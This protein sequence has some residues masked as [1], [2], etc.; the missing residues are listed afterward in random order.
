M[1]QRIIMAL[2]ALHSLVVAFAGNIVVGDLTMKPGET[3]ALEISLSGSVSNVYGIQFDIKLPKEFSFVKG[4]GDKVFEMAGNQA[5][6]ITCDNSELGEG[7]YRFLIY[8]TTLQ[9]L[10][11][12]SLISVNLI[13]N[14]TTTLGNYSVTI[15]NVAVS[16]S[17][18]HVT[19]EDGIAVSVKVTDFFTL[20]YQVDGEEYKSFEMEYGAIISPES[21]PTKEG[22]TFSGWNE[23]PETMPAQDVTIM[24]TFTAN[25]YKLTYFVDGKEYKTFEVEYGTSVNK[26]AF[27]EQEGYTFSGWSEIPETMPAHDVTVTGSFTVNTYTLTY[28]VDG[29]VYKTVD[30]AYGTAITPEDE[31]AKEGYTFS[32]WGDIATTMPANDVTVSGTF[33]VNTYT[34]TYQLDGEFY[35]SYDIDFGSAITPE[36]EPTKEGYSFSGWSEIPEVMPALDITVTGEFTINKYML[37]YI[38]DGEEYKSLELEYG[39]T[40]NSEAEPEKEG[41]TF[42]GWSEIPETMPAYDVIINGTFSVNTYTLTYIVDS[43]VYTTYVIDYGTAITPEED[44]TKEGHTFSGWSDIPKTMPAHDVNVTG[45]FTK[46]EY[47]LTYIVNGETYLTVSYDYGTAVIPE[48]EPTKEGYTFS[49]WSDIP[50]TMPANDITVTGTFTINSYKLTYVVDGEEYK[51]FEIE[52]GTSLNEEAEPEKEGHTFS[53]WSDIPETMPAN[54]V[55]IN[56]KFRI[57]TYKLT[58]VVDGQEYKSFEVEYGSSIDA[59]AEPTKEGH[60]FSGW[61]ELPET[62]PA[63]DLVATGSFTINKYVMTYTVDGEEYK[64]FEVEY[65][66][67]ITAEAI[68]EKEGYTFSGWSEI[69][70]TMP[71]NDVTVTG[72]FTVNT[73][74]LTYQVDGE[75]YKTCEVAYGTAITPEAEPEKEGY[76]FSGW[77]EMPETMPA[78]DVAVTG[79]FTINTYQVTYIIGG[80]V[81][82]TDSVQYG[83][84]IVVPDA[85]EREDYTFDGWADVPETMPAHDI[86]IY[87]SYTS[88]IVDVSINEKNVI[89]YDVKGRRI[90]KLQRG[91]NIIRTRD[92]RMRKVMVK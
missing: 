84:A 26:E 65:G 50:E 57:N 15:S 44:P 90:P 32:G 27:P 74:T 61:S 78:N 40:L 59:E 91:V 36:A 18:G 12:G 49:G 25:K 47:K 45:T 55:T 81:F 33:T 54:D 30:Y 56:G 64:T 9:E 75:V 1:K 66:S 68:P 7:V 28:M 80:E 62:M 37:T 10:R 2:V 83:A 73:Y 52:Y 41:Y 63:K 16:D 86:V 51:S 46:G 24:G 60:T 31:P 20:M 82:K 87:G 69:P 71:A 13:A 72:S 67:S 85:T 19:K 22:Y 14:K 58:Y 6:D 48:A 34:I 53:G 3:K 43:A 4:S 29:E 11:G 76:T 70:E 23:I 17:E 39:T 77:S 8:S 35:K 5:E 92:G 88:G 21:E 38:V 42:S 89:I 79:T